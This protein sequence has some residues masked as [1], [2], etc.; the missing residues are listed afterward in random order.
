V[1]TNIYQN[2]QVVGTSRDAARSNA[3]GVR[4]IGAGRA[5]ETILRGVQRNQAVIA[6]PA[7]VSVAWRLTCLFPSLADRGA[8]RVVRRVRRRRTADARMGS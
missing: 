1:R 4:M 5:A 7:Y 3:A 8:A 6:F 2:A